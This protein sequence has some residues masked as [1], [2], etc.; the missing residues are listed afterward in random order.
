MAYFDD[1]IFSKYNTNFM[2]YS[3]NP[4]ENKEQYQV[5]QIWKDKS[6]APTWEEL[7]A[8]I[9]KLRVKE[10]RAKQYPAIGE[11]LDMLWH[12]IDSGS[13][14]KDSE[15]YKTLKAVKEQNPGV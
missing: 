2:G 12:A 3:G 4:P 1:V 7:S 10:T 13:L 11:Q 5:M 14:D 9:E 15:F 6:T 8:D